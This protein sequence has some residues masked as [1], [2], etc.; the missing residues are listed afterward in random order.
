MCHNITKRSTIIKR[1]SMYAGCCQMIC[2]LPLPMA[3]AIISLLPQSF[4]L[5]R[6]YTVWFHLLSV[7]YLFTQ[8]SFIRKI[9]ILQGCGV[10]VG[11]YS[12][13]I[14]D[15]L[16]DGTFCHTLYRN[17]PCVMMQYMI[18]DGEDE[19]ETSPITM[20]SDSYII[21]NTYSSLIMKA[22]SHILDLLL[23]PGLAYLF[24]RIHHNQ[25]YH[26]NSSSKSSSIWKDI[27]TWPIIVSAWHLSRIWSMVH[28]YYNTGIIKLWYYGHDVYQMNNLDSFMI[29]YAAEGLCF[30]VAISFR[31]YWDNYL[32]SAE[33]KKC[34]E[35][36]IALDKMQEEPAPRLI[37]SESA[38]STS[39]LM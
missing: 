35:R 27:L 23:H 14:F 26:N 39:S 17:M 18:D 1:S 28:T 25:H 36:M 7:I 5:N 10:C 6:G 34:N 15:W 8:S 11:W 20:T 16:A 13:I 31:V 2:P 12:A 9:L 30:A 29:A 22:L 38:V 33:K 37:H 24:Y 3:I 21:L 19:D 4:Y 32:D